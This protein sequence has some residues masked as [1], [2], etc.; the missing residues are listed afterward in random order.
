MGRFVLLFD[1]IQAVTSY[2]DVPN[3]STGVHP[4][5]WPKIQASTL[6]RVILKGR[7]VLDRQSKNVYIFYIKLG[8]LKIQAVNFALFVRQYSC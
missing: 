6:I 3:K 1:G 8:F 5:T 4:K 7:S 2:S